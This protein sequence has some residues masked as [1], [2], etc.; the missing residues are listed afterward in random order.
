M[1]K[2]NIDAIQK[3][4][5]AFESQPEDVL[6]QEKELDSEVAHSGI[7]T[8]TDKVIHGAEEITRVIISP[9]DQPHLPTLTFRFWVL[10][11]GL[12]IF[13]SVL[14]EIYFW[15]PQNATV[16]NLFQLIVAYVLG[17]AMHY[18]M[19]SKG[20]WRYLNP[21]PFNIKEHTC[22]TMMASTASSSAFAIGVIATLDLFYNIKLNPAA[23]IFQSF[24][25]QLIGYGF[26]GILRSLLVW[27]TYALHPA[28]IP[29][30]SLLQ[31]MH[32]DGLLNK[33]KMQYF[34][35]VFTC[36]FIWVRIS[37]SF[38]IPSHL[39]FCPAVQEIVPT[40]I[41][42]LLTSFS[43]I[44]LADTG[45]HTV[46]RNLFGAGSSNEGLGLFSFGFDWMLI[47]QAFPLY[48]PLQTQV[49]SWVGIALCYI[50]LMGCYYGD[51]FEGKSRGL[52]FLS[53]SLFSGNGS[54]YDQS[55]ILTPANQLDA[56]KFAEIGPPYM[57]TTY[58][59][60]LLTAYAAL[61]AAFSHVLLWHWKEL[62]MAFKGF[63]FLKSGQDFDDVHY[64]K[65]KVY[66]EVPQWWYGLTFLVSLALAIGMAYVGLETL[67]WWSVIL[68]TVLAF[69]ISI[70][71]GFIFAVTGFQIPT[72][73][74]VQVIAAYVHPQQPIQNMYAKLYGYNTGYQTL[75]MLADLKLGQYAKVPPRATFISQIAGTILGAGFNYIL[76]KSIVDAHRADLINPIGTRIWS[77]WNSQDINSAAITWGA[78][79]KELYS[80]GKMYFQIPMG[81]LYGFLAPFPLYF[82]HRLFPKQKIWSY[83]NVP[84]IITYLGWLTYSVNGAWWPGFVIGLWTQ[85]WVR[86]RKP[87]WYNKYNFLTSAAL[88][89]G[90]SIVYFILS[91]A[92]FGAS[93]QG[94]NF[95]FWWGNPD[96]AMMSVDHCAMSSG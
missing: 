24:A 87:R 66:K 71:L 59:I 17:N 10:G 13:G 23:A 52:P 69:I 90:S 25:S 53:A 95:P 54:L 85:W 31:S 70:I 83:L 60:S 62:W 57:T 51:V 55:A 20:I 36:I 12:S 19:P 64:Q 80:P 74:V 73:G 1:A 37:V 48:W 28:N 8:P 77:G 34:W 35:I 46:V 58:A 96:P 32:F 91:F 82:L 27:P 16:S 3:D 92:V 14:S 38:S 49:S 39:F 56:V 86:T 63:N 43:V 47:T 75:Y 89:G 7:E 50:L 41:F 18:V 72:F 44:C 94:I 40:W 15:K 4:A 81:L 61:G 30:I 29:L 88:D 79:S 78:L 93:G 5:I 68:F 67:P 11:I 33:K 76:Y 9:D 21:G 65:M 42:P 26:A 45:Q 2:C 84:V 22:I 6:S